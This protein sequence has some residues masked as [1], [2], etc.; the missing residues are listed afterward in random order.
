MGRKLLSIWLVLVFFLSGLSFHP[1]SGIQE[2]QAGVHIVNALLGFLRIGGAFEQ[3]NRVYQEG[4]RTVGEINTYYNRQITQ[5]QLTRQKMVARVQKGELHVSFINAYVRVEAALEA[6][7]K[8]AIQMVEAEKN[9]ARIDF[10]KTVI[11]EIK[12]VLVSSSGAQRLI[13]RLGDAVWETRQVLISA[14]ESLEEGKPT[15]M[16]GDLLASKVGDLEVA[17]ELARGL[18]S[19][20]GHQLDKLTGGAIGR[21]ESDIVNLQESLGEG[22]QTLD[23]IDAE[24]DRL[25]EP[26]WQPISL[27]EDSSMIVEFFPVDRQNSVKDV[28]AS[29]FAGAAMISGRNNPNIT[30]ATMHDRIRAALLDARVARIRELVSGKAVGLIYCNAVDREEYEVAVLEMGQILLPPANPG[31][32]RFIVCYDIPTQKPVYV[33]AYGTAQEPADLPVETQGVEEQPTATE[34]EMSP[35]LVYKGVVSPAQGNLKILS[36]QVSLKT[37]DE[38]V[39]AVIEMTFTA[40]V[41]WQQNGSLCTATMTRVYSG[42]GKLGADIEIKLNLDSHQDSLTGKD[43]A[44]VVVPVIASQTLTGKFHEDGRFTGNIRNVWVISALRVED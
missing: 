6:E 40:D 9:Q 31:T 17:Q 11:N 15:D 38:T 7:R 35:V 10:K 23:E 24:I 21:L 3:R 36:S 29:A 44:D 19:E 2:V 20:V 5:A 41:K 28:V 18:G 12:N 16:L 25:G 1:R 26:G 37:T 13:R 30:R 27:V 33:K 32:A 8:V 42:Q 14:Q 4:G 39:S 34:V 43:C 22:L